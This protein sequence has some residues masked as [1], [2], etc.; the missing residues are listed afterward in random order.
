MNTTPHRRPGRPRINPLTRAEQLRAAKR[1][2]RARDKEAGLVLCQLRLRAALAAKL[3]TAAA[4]HRF[5]EQLERFLDDAVIDVRRYPNLALLCWNR[6]DRFVTDRDAFNLYERNWRFVDTKT[7][8]Q[9]ERDLIARLATKFGNG[10][11]NV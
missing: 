5:D 10:V 7:M 8:P 6:K 9:E 11:L 3:Q 1:A 4:L 2:Q